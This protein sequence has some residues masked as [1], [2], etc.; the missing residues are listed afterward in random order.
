MSLIFFHFFVLFF[1]FFALNFLLRF[2]LVIFAS[3]RGEGE[4]FF[5]SKEANKVV[6]NKT[7]KEVNNKVKKVVVK[8]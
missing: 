4:N 2:D 7:K 6:N 5:A 1:A 3:K 8:L